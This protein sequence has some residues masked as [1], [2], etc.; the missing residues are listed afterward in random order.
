MS[1]N[2]TEDHVRKL[3]YECRHEL[4]EWN[5][6]LQDILKKYREGG[7]EQ[8]VTSPSVTLPPTSKTRKEP[9]SVTSPATSEVSVVSELSLCL[10]T[11]PPKKKIKV[12]DN[13][14]KEP[15]SQPKRRRFVD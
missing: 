8:S 2:Q 10:L 9:A 7:E 15:T 1:D 11:P 14:N 12:E 6:E 4:E 3:V 13:E 5:N